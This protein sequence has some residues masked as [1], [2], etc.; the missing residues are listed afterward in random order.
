MRQGDIWLMEQRSEK[1]RLLLVSHNGSPT[2]LRHPHLDDK[3]AIDESLSPI[4][5]P[6]N[7]QMYHPPA[8]HN[9]TSILAQLVPPCEM[10]GG[11]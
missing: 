10:A 1:A 7:R 8:A 3:W 2:N 6:A 5:D 11:T 4:I 9:D